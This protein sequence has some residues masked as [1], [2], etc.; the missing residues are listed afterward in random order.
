VKP[1]TSFAGL[2][3][4][5]LILAAPPVSRAQDPAILGDNSRQAPNA[6]R[7]WE[8]DRPSYYPRFGERRPDYSR[9][10]E[11]PAIEPPHWVQHDS[12]KAYYGWFVNGIQVAVYNSRTNKYWTYDPQTDAW[13]KPLPPPW[14]RQ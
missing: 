10:V 2:T 4:L 9:F 13:S 7:I 8:R 11:A 6:R 3:T 12:D 14:E 5:T 1:I